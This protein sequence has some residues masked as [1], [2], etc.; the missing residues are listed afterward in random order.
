MSALPSRRLS[1]GALVAVAAVLL[2]ACSSG[3]IGSI[4]QETSS[5]GSPNP[6]PS[7]SGSVQP[8]LARFYDQKPAWRACGGGF[9]CASV[10]VP[11]DYAA[12]D[13][14]AIALAVI[15]LPASSPAAR[16]GALVTDPGG[17]GASG[18][19]FA[20]DAKGLFSAGL[21][22]RYDIVGFD[23]RGVQRSAPV[24]CLSDAQWDA[25]NAYDGSPD[26]TA[27]EA[28]LAS[29]DKELGQSCEARSAHVLGH[30]STVESAKDMDILRAILGQPT[31]DYFGFSYGTFLGATYADLF[32][33][34]VGRMAL[35]GAMDPSL[36]MVGLQ[37]GQAKGFELALDRFVA[38]C[39]HQSDCPL[40]GGTQAGLAKLQ[41]FFTSLDAH[42]LPTGDDKRPLTQALG[43]GAVID[44]LYFPAYGDWDQLR[45][46][47][48]AA[49]DGDGSVMLAMFDQFQGRNDAGKYT[50]NLAS[51]YFSVE[52]LDYP[53]RPDVA[54]ARV[55]A[56]QWAKEAPLLGA[57]FAWATMSASFWPVAATGHPHEI[58]APGS[59]PILVVGSTYDPATPY[60]WAQ[61]LAS[62]LSK[63]VLLTRVG[64][65][66]TAYGKGSAC[67]DSAVDR[68]LLTGVTPPIGTVCH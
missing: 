6:S 7:T 39:Q 56:A 31:L 22:A 33:T 52:A 46:G 5:A 66:H 64:D 35:D 50:S 68:Y 40:P 34:K 61:A 57:T 16:I 1:V 8:G 25:F 60:P 9:L 42:P 65:G 11:I 45:S 24:N 67:I 14:D 54:Q 48:Q 36:G 32:P 13:G 26:T 19:D 12:P 17:P 15:K 29:W 59:P 47:L 21:R 43:V 53:D 41:Q 20:R 4:T 23:P 18:V 38:D 3:T 28:G 63:G 62:Q 58:H 44:Y 51:S 2:A 49:F 37:H 10:L 30:V 55:L 27:E